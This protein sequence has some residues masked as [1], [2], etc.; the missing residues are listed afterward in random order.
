M[1]WWAHGT[2]RAHH[3]G[4]KELDGSKHPSQDDDPVWAHKAP[5]NDCRREQSCLVSRPMMKCIAAVAS[6]S[7]STAVHGDREHDD[8]PCRLLLQSHQTAMPGNKQA[9]RQAQACNKG[10]RALTRGHICPESPEACKQRGSHVKGNIKAHSGLCHD[11]WAQLD[12]EISCKLLCLATALDPLHVTGA[13]LQIT[14][15]RLAAI[16]SI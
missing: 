14:Y 12:N 16:R 15:S 7:G 3:G 10:G 2:Q 9:G 1:P 8:A 13:G 5:Q 11:H 6:L 4:P